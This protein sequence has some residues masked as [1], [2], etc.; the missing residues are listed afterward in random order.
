[1][2]SLEASRG[3]IVWSVR[4]RDPLALLG[5]SEQVDLAKGISSSYACFMCCPNSFRMSWIEPI[6]I[7]LPEGNF[8]TARGAERD[9][10]CYGSMTPS[11][12][13][14]DT[15]SAS[16]S[17]IFSVDG[18]GDAAD[19]TGVSFGSGTLTAHWEV[20]SFTMEHADGIPFCVEQSEMTEPGAPTEVQ[21]RAHHLLVGNDLLGSTN[22]CS[23]AKRIIDWVVVDEPGTHPVGSISIIEVPTGS[24]TDSCANQEVSY[25]KT[26]N[27]NAVNQAGVFEDT[28][29]TGCP[30]SGS[31]GF[32]WEP[33][34]WKWCN[35]ATKVT[36]A[37][38]NYN[39]HHNEIKVRG[40]ATSLEG[41]HLLPDGTMR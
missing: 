6:S 11:Y 15:W 24:T 37:K 2:I 27:P 26:C 9:Q 10:T 36:L 20:Y 28:L 31:C 3:K 41:K 21:R 14:G 4:G 40:V 13:Y 29:Q 30:G 38:L 33:N 18:L 17:S 35:G 16:N 12:F 23:G 5:R 34:E 22:G 32:D 8:T 39:V 25:T 19:V 1:M 7:S